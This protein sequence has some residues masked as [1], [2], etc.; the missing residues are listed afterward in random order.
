MVATSTYQVDR[1]DRQV[2][3]DLSLVEIRVHRQ[4]NLEENYSDR[5][6]VDSNRIAIDL[7]R[8]SDSGYIPKYFFIILSRHGPDDVL[9]LGP[10]GYVPGIPD[11]RLWAW[12]RP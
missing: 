7:N 9:V 1:Q 2:V 11:G 4:E 5:Y 8:H 12:F 10:I 6:H 3:Q